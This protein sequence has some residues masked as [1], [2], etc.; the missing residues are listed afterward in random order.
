[1]GELAWMAWAWESL[2]CPLL[3]GKRDPAETQADYLSYYPDQSQDLD[4]AQL[5]NYP[6]DELL[7]QGKGPILH[8][9]S[10]RTPG[11][12]RVS[13]RSFEEGSVLMVQQ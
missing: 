11:N 6:I 13:E 4:L 7:E 9:H 3:R 8:S 12:N 2:P 1:M 5:N 10:H